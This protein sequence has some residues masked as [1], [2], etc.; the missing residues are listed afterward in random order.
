VLE[1]SLIGRAEAAALR[2][3]GGLSVGGGL[4]ASTA[5]FSSLWA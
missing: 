4:A 1:G 5:W 3:V 2:Q